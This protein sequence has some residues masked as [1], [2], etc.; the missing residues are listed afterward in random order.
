MYIK[1]VFETKLRCMTHSD[2]FTLGMKKLWEQAGLYYAQA[3]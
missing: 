2:T 3:S 1:I